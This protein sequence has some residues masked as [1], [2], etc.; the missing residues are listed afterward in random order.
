M[1]PTGGEGT[2]ETVTTA[3][4]PA[5]DVP[6][7]P[8]LLVATTLA[9]TLAPV[10]SEKGAPSKVVRLTVQLLVDMIVA[11]VPSQLGKA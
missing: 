4:L 7:D 5:D 6:D 9:H 10:L 3:P 11:S 8:I 2:V 1:R